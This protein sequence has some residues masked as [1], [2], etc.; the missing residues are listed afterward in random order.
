M[1]LLKDS[2]QTQTPALPFLIAKPYNSGFPD[3]HDTYNAITAASDGKIYYVLCSESI[4]QGGQMFVYDPYTDQVRFLADLTTVCGEAGEKAIPQGKSHVEFYE[5]NGKLY[6]ATHIGT[7]EMINDVERLPKN[8]PKGYSLYPGGH[9]LSYDLSNGRF[10]DLGIASPGE[11]IV[12]MVMDKERGQIYGITWPNGYFI[13]F[14][15]NNR[16]LK[17]VGRLSGEGEAGIPGDS[18]RVLCRSL[19][20]DPRDGCAYSST[21]EGYILKY[22]PGLKALEK[23][24]DVSLQ[25]DYFGTYDYR[26]PGSMG[27]NWRKIL[28]Y[29][30]GGVAYGVHGNSGYLFRFDPKACTI[31]IVE[32]ITSKPSRRSGMF[33]QFTFGYLGFQLGPDG[34]TIHYLTGGPIYE[35]GK[36]LKGDDYILVGS[37]GQENLHLV[38]YHIANDEY[39]DHGPVFYENGDQPTYVNSLAIGNSDVI[40]TIA[41]FDCE[42]KPACDL[43]KISYP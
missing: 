12:T 4:E 20:V 1:T 10:E 28:W 5:Y 17:N 26:Q 25:L 30:P 16:E 24:E 37:K 15:V 18:Y 36:R 31:E 21:T 13:H 29:E 6:F 8:P 14:D 39:E 41:R 42:G 22:S 40:F 19:L 7:Y 32:R 34:Q 35:K 11:G 33:D 38:T 9:I 27:Y 2:K 43:I 23:L 3:A